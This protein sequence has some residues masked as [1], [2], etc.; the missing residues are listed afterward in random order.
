MIEARGHLAGSAAP[1]G[2]L[3]FPSSLGWLNFTTLT[4]SSL[5]LRER[6]N[7]APRIC[8]ALLWQ[9]QAALPSTTQLPLVEFCPWLLAPF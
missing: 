5:G 6:A 9:E 2:H 7:L 1:P 3:V 4:T 8:P